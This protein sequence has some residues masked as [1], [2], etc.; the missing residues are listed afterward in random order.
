MSRR[1]PIRRCRH[2][3]LGVVSALGLGTHLWAQAPAASTPMGWSVAGQLTQGVDTNVTLALQ[4]PQAD[5]TSQLNLDLSGHWAGPRW[6][7][8]ATYSPR[9][10]AYARRSYLDYV[11]QSY[12]QAWD[13]DWTRHTHL[14][15]VSSAERYPERGGAPLQGSGLVAAVGA[16]Q[17]QPLATVLANATSTLTLSHQYSQRGSWTAGANL[18]LQAFT[19]D[20]SLL[21]SANG[22]AAEYPAVPR[23]QS[24]SFGGNLGWSYELTAHRSLQLSSSFSDLAYSNPARSVRY[25]NVQASLEQGIG[26]DLTLNLG[27][28][29]SWNFTVTAP[30]GPAA[31]A[32]GLAAQSYAAHAGLTATHGRSQF[33][34]SWQH[35]EQLG[36]VP[37]GVTTDVEAA[38]YSVQW[39][40]S[41]ST[42]ASIGRSGVAGFVATPT[43]DSAFAS[44]QLND[45]IAP[46]WSLLASSSYSVQALPTSATTTSPFRRLQFSLGVAF[47]PGG[48]R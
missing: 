44:G 19:P 18:S 33:G 13:F 12:N 22:N 23:S 8:L 25:A 15:W 29:P 2:A 21:A 14:T 48:P 41:W 43:R 9:G 7:F 40:K 39:G 3:L 6:S 1:P 26:P 36:L 20:K 5:S 42:A 46:D 45:R 34:V 28:G 35:S 4:Q 30:Q 37:G 31:A 47:S 17:Q 27:V 11:A 10:E 32:P 16:S 38:Q 24:Q